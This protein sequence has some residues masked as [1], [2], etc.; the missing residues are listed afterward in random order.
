MKISKYLFLIG[1]LYLFSS[2]DAQ[3]EPGEDLKF[4]V[5]TNYSSSLFKLLVQTKN[6]DDVT[7]DLFYR[8]KRD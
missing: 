6:C 8:K 3:Q 5:N 1:S 4:K 2:I 7:K